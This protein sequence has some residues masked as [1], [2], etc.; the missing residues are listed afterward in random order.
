MPKAN[1]SRATGDHK[2]QLKRLLLEA[3]ATSGKNLP[4]GV[5][6][7][8]VRSLDVYDALDLADDLVVTHGHMQYAAIVNAARTPP[9]AEAPSEAT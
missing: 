7:S 4:G 2:E 5:T 8:D 9:S 1:W 3:I 6:E